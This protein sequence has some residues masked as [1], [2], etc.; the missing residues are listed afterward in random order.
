MLIDSAFSA[1]SKERAEALVQIPH[2][3]YVEHGERILKHVAQNRLPS[4]YSHS[5]DVEN[6]G[7][8]SYGVN[9]PR[10]VPPYGILCRQDSE[11]HQAG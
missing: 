8:M 11:G 1:M 9:Y 5:V 6:G 4:I 3:R 2:A 7:L 10:R